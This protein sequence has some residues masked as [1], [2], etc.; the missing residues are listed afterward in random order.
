MDLTEFY[1]LEELTHLLFETD[2]SVELLMAMSNISPGF[3]NVPSVSIG[4]K[5]YWHRKYVDKWLTVFVNKVVEVP[6]LRSNLV[7]ELLLVASSNV[8]QAGDYDRYNARSEIANVLEKYNIT[9]KS[10]D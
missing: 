5:K 8:I 7:E 6:D 4:G 1:T 3:T 2:L 10:S 9:K